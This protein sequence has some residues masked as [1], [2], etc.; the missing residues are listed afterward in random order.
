[1]TLAICLLVN[2]LGAT[3]LGPPILERLTGRVAA[4]LAISAWIGTMGAVLA[5]WA[6]AAALA[7]LALLHANGHLHEVLDGCLTMIDKLFG[8]ALYGAVQGGLLI[9]AALSVIVVAVLIGRL[10][11]L[12]GRSRTRTHRHC[13][14]AWLVGERRPGPG[15]SLVLD[16]AE[17]V[18]YCVAGRRPAIV[19]TR[20]ALDALDEKQLAA[21]LSH[22]RAHLAGRHH[23]LVAA[24]RAVATV[25]PR[26]RLFSAGAASVVRLVE[27]RA[28]EVAVRQHGR[29]ALV[30]ALLAL[31][32]AGPVPAAAL[33]AS[34]VGVAARVERLLRPPDTAHPVPAPLAVGLAAVALVT[35]PFLTG[36]AL[37]AVPTLCSLV[38][39]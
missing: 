2:S 27:I 26:I 14:L 24:S 13:E 23:L 32:G 11:L 28:D 12:L 8:G 38:L 6:V 37:S 22:E 9:S 3:V 35:G 4:R 1:M 20:G 31:S 33:G 10:V 25:L 21:V 29:S 5:S 15:G 18:V 39:G 19:I 34:S 36:A 16:S 17:H 7:G 30:G